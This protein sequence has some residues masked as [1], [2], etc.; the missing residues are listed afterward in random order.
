MLLERLNQMFCDICRNYGY[1]LPG[2][3]YAPE[4]RIRGNCAVCSSE[5]LEGHE[6][7]KDEDDITFCSDRCAMEY[8]GIKIVDE[9]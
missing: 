2:C 8:H 9:E 5:L 7:Y 1:H 4:P 6:Y 3:P